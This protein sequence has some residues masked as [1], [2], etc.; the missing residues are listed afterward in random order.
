M[1]PSQAQ[2]WAG[3]AE[4]FMK[5]GSMPVFDKREFYQSRVGDFGPVFRIDENG[6]VDPS[7]S[8]QVF[9]MYDPIAKYDYCGAVGSQTWIQLLA[10][11]NADSAIKSILLWVDSPGGQVDGTEALANAIKNSAKP[12]V[13][14]TDGLMCSAAYWIGSSA[15]EVICDGAN[16]GWNATIGSIGTMV[17][18]LDDTG[19]MEKEGLKR[20]MVFADASSDK[21]G[22][23]FSV[24]KG[25]YTRLKQELNGINETFL[26][27][28]KD[29]RPNLKL[30]IEN[31]L[32]GKTYSANEALKY[33]LI[34]KIGSFD[35]AVKR[36]A[37]LAKPKKTIMSKQNISFQNVMNVAGANE[38]AVAEGGFM[39]TEEQLNKIDA[40]LDQDATVIASTAAQ[41]KTLQAGAQAETTAQEQNTQ[42]T[43]QVETLT[44]KVQALETENASLKTKNAD[45]ETA[46]KQFFSGTLGANGKQDTTPAHEATATEL[47]QLE[48]NVM[49]DKFFGK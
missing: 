18:Y 40:K 48:H 3:I 38:I 15:S 29:S 23:Y 1:E 46:G 22:D 27:A 2:H 4:S 14:Y 33:G 34:D 16:N 26:S 9:R 44:A 8:I 12:V 13:A 45:L 11:A 6:T 36:A 43:A 5:T 17:M 19:R 21:W 20:V 30:D 28:V 25:D 35:V 37:Q 39:L 47:D 41:L 10:A 32:T 7:G 24:M 31:V 49:A 42:L